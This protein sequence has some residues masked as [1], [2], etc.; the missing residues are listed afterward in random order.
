MEKA[1]DKPFLTII[2]EEVFGPASMEHSSTDRAADMGQNRAK[3]YAGAFPGRKLADAA[4]TD[5]SYKWAG[6]GLASTPSDLARF[7]AAML[8][9][10]LVGGEWQEDMLTARTLAS[11]EVNE[12]SY[13]LGW[14]IG[15]IEV[16]GQSGGAKEWTTLIHHGGNTAGSTA[17]LLLLPDY[18]LVVALTAN[19]IR[20][21]GSGP[22]TEHATS[23]LRIFVDYLDESGMGRGRAGQES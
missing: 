9:G 23:I 14:R 2:D 16:D 3:G 8:A 12:Q 18:D 10:E 5:S 1:T 11:G 21:D 19:A 17:I 13:G 4:A 22:V 20:D 6:G 7:G 15:G